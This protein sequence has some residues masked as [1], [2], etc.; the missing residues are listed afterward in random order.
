[1]QELYEKAAELMLKR[2][3]TAALTG[4][5]VS[6]ESG[7]PDFRSPE[8]LWHRFDPVEYATIQ[9]FRNDPKK[10]WEMLFA[11]DEIV[12]S[13]SPNASHR[14]LAD[15]EEMGVVEA[16]ITQNIDGLHQAA[17]SRRVIEFHGNPS[18][19]VCLEGCGTFQTETLRPSIRRGR[20][21]ICPSCGRILKPDVV[22]FGEAIPEGAMYAAL[23][24]ARYSGTIIVAGTSA[25]V[26]PASQIPVMASQLG[27]AVIE[28]NLEP[29]PLTPAA[30]VTIL[31][32][33]S[34]TLPK[35][36]AEVRR[37]LGQ[38]H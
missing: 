3:P 15:L 10:V 1:M 4:A 29:T 17:G 2:R 30:D 31:G 12:A 34:Q 32:P 16:V 37:M 14:A 18:R 19:L 8:G 27:A 21:P 38:H 20:P 26:A 5:G 24:L 22:L 9:A 25:T 28:A 13:A 36:A 35:L 11:V 23:H 6:V 33:A 7:I